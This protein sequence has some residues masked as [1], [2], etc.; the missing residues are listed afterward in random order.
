MLA[1]FWDDGFFFTPN[2]GETLIVRTKDL[3]D[4]A[5]PSATSIACKVLLRT[6]TLVEPPHLTYASKELEGLAGPAS[7][8]PF[9]LSQTVCL[10]NRLVR[11]G[12]DVVVAGSGE[13]A[14][15]LGAA[16]ARRYVPDLTL[17]WLVP[18][19]AASLEACAALAEGKGA[20]ANGPVAYV[21]KGRSC[22][23]PLASGEAIEDA[24]AHA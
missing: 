2:D 8:N 13:K 17:A 15:A 20:G 5:V 19:D 14:R 3:F 24:L 11:G 6:A 21:C 18:G 7:E 22:S 23:L 4:H 10:L 16:A 1:H 12:V 9:G